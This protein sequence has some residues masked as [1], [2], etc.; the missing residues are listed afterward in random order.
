[1]GGGGG[2]GGHMMLKYREVGEA[3][4]VWRDVEE[5]AVSCSRQHGSPHQEHCQQQVRQQGRHI[6]HLH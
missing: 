4:E 6:H 1:M 2:V 5:D 3:R